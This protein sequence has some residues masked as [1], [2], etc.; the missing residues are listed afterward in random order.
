M[1]RE[2]EPSVSLA[3]THVVGEEQSARARTSLWTALW[4]ALL[5]A[6]ALQLTRNK[7]VT[8]WVLTGT[9]LLLA[10]ACSAVL[11]EARGKALV[12]PRRLLITGVMVVL[13]TLAA[14]A[15]LGVLSPTFAFLIVTVYYNSSGDSP[16]E[17][18]IYALSA[19]GYSV[20]VGLCYFGVLPLTKAVLAM[21]EQNNRAL[22]GFGIVAEGMLFATYRMAKQNRMATLVA[23]ERLER[24]QRQVQQR[25]ALLLEARAELAGAHAG[26]HGRH[27]GTQVGGYLIGSLVGRG[28]M[29]EVYEATASDG[30]QAALKIL[31]PEL[32]EDATHVAR[33]VREA[34]LTERLASPH[35]VKVL[36]GG[37]TKD[38]CPYVAMEL[39]LGED[40]GEYLRE[41]RTL[42]LPA[43]VDMVLQ[44][45][46]GLD[47]AQEKGIVHRDLKPSNLFLARDASG[48]Q[49]WKVLDF[50]VAA[51]GEAAGELTR[52]AA[53]GT[54]HY[55]SPE[56]TR[57]E[58]VDH[59]SDVFALG[60]ITYR[61][62]TG[63]P[64]FAASDSMA[65]MYR[66]NHVQPTR[67]SLLVPLPADVDAV[68]ALALA[69]EKSVRFRSA[70]TFAS[71]LRDAS[72]GELDEPF[73]V[74]ARALLARHP[75]MREIR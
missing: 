25:D 51:L 11:W 49:S 35:I 70:S 66:V 56:Q 52:G 7:N 22:L 73:R 44:V 16:Y 23:M 72:R 41:H 63:Q 40:L 2:T 15:R 71:A 8:H 9:I 42:A 55:M 53:V 65:A 24:A 31:H 1:S 21:S 38:G 58:P 67:P 14:T 60:A 4:L 29:G 6:L 12:D 61:A 30:S 33:F 18:I 3:T 74:A 75:W 5:A 34:E 45:A 26:R 19:V 59:R 54:P 17:G 68:I 39:L 50:G 37:K 43:T 62:L 64:A 69:K 10:L 47:T 27:S 28:A 20:V 48:R 57:G 13:V 46:R 36:G 32:L